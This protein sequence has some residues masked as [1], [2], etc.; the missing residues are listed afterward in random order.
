M[1]LYDQLIRGPMKDIYIQLIERSDLDVFYSGWRVYI[2][3]YGQ[4]EGLVF[5]WA[6]GAADCV[7]VDFAATRPHFA[8]VHVACDLIDNL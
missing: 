1:Y 6:R 2:G 8:R 5:V 4:H 3:T 7:F